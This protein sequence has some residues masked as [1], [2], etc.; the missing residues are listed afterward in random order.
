VRLDPYLPAVTLGP[1]VRLDPGGIG[2]GLAADIV[3]GELIERG[4]HGAMVN[5]GGDVSVAGAAPTQA[6]WIVGVEDPR[7]RTR[8]V[9]RVALRAGGVCTSS[10]LRRAWI[11]TSGMPVHHLVDPRTGM[12]VDTDVASV[13]VVAGAAWWAEALTKARFVGTVAGSPDH[14]T[15]GTHALLV[16]LDGRV[17]VEGDAGVFGVAES[18]V[19]TTSR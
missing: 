11:D 18:V 19:G 8:S 15:A 7:D 1:D 10:R 2:K 14:L 6:G 17:T 5:L 12:P 4:A 3:V 13:T 9:A 16:S